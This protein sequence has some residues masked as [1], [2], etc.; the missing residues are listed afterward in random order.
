MKLVTI[1][2]RHDSRAC[3]VKFIT[4]GCTTII[5]GDMEYGGL[6]SVGKL[7]V[8]KDEL[9]RSIVVITGLAD[10]H[11]RN[12]GYFN[13]SN[14]N[15]ICSSDKNGSNSGIGFW[16][17]GAVLGYNCVNDRVITLHIHMS[18]NSL[19]LYKCM[20]PLITPMKQQ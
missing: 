9:T 12:S 5:A 8:L 3:C 1:P 17:A 16:Y 6:L 13:F 19:T 14:W 20:L 4:E 18:P 2:K 7:S 15:F 10:T 11:F